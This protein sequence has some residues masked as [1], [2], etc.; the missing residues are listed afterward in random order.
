MMQVLERTTWQLLIVVG[1]ITLFSPVFTQAA[2]TGAQP[3]LEILSPRHDAGSHWEGEVVAHSFQVRNT[4][5]G[6][7]RILS[8]R[9]G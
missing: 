2:A 5:S 7:L 9:P 6:E 3:A 4:G 1:L 8:V